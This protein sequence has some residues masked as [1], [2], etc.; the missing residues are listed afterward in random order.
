MQVKMR[1]LEK[2]GR[3]DRR[4]EGSWAGPVTIEMNLSFLF[5]KNDGR[6]LASDIDLRIYWNLN[7]AIHTM[8]FILIQ[9]HVVCR[10]IS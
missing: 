1:R 6:A 5:A 9:R 2:V 4:L 7:L 10:K 8:R 3:G